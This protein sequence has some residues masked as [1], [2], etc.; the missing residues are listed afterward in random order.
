MKLIYFTLNKIGERFFFTF[1]AQQELLMSAALNL[2]GTQKPDIKEHPGKYLSF[3]GLGEYPVVVC[4][5]EL[6]AFPQATC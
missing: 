2:R 6:P 4:N 1:Q 5:A 3:A